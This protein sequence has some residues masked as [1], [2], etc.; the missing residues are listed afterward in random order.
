M[1]ENFAILM[2]EANQD[3]QEAWWSQ[4]RILEKEIY[5]YLY[6]SEIVE[7]S[8]ERKETEDRLHIRDDN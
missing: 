1:G 5:L 7:H 6:N 4:S 8:K 3:L 2:K